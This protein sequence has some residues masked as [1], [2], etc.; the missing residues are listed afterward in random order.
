MKKLIFTLIAG[1]LFTI[2]GH[3][4]KSKSKPAFESGF[5]EPKRIWKNGNSECEPI[6]SS[7]KVHSGD[8]SYE[9]GAFGKCNLYRDFPLVENATVTIWFY[10]QVEVTGIAAAVVNNTEAKEN[11]M[12]GIHTRVDKNNYCYRYGK[13]FKPTTVK[14][15]T[16]WH[17]M[18]YVFT[19]TG[20]EYFIDSQ[21]VIKVE[22]TNQINAIRLGS[23]WGD[24]NSGSLFF[25]DIKVETKK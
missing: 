21:S 11:F 3:A 20:C 17:E 24:V 22:S 15:T 6:I 1:S 7:V 25:D 19:A 12:M 9:I 10:D 23:V 18:K 2:A 13:D 5:E 16:G 8:K 14:R 4:Q